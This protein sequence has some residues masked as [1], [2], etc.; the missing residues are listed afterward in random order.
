MYK[1]KKITICL[2]CKNESKHLHKVIEMIP[3]FVDEIIVISNNSSDDTYQVAKNLGVKVFEDDRTLNGNGEGFAY[4][5][6]IRNATGDII[7]CADADCTYPTDKIDKMLD[8]F[9][10][11]NI[12]FMSGSRYPKQKESKIGFK[13]QLGV[14]VLNWEIFFLYGIKINDALSGMWIFKKDIVDDLGILTPKWIGDWN[15]S[16]QIKINAFGNPKLKCT[17]YSIVQYEREGQTNQAY[18]K[19]GFGHLFWIFLNRFGFT[20]SKKMDLILQ[21]IDIHNNSFS[22]KIIPSFELFRSNNSHTSPV[23]LKIDEE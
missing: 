17:E 12:D 15:H 16:P 1:N 19:T 22:Q 3:S 18:F 20:R 23:A 6:G 2:P 4:Q 7:V 21:P 8:K 11:Q 10:D 14:T 13:Q 9:L 5:T